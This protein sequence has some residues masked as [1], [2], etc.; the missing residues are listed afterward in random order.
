M[1][2]KERVLKA[3][4]HEITDKVPVDLG[5]NIQATIHAYAYHNLKQGLGLSTDR[6]EIMDTYIMAAKVEDTV[7]DALQIDA[8]PILCPFDSLG[9]RNGPEKK[10]WIMPNGL[11][12]LVSEDFDP[13]KQEDGSYIIEKNGFKFKMP[14]HGYYFDAIHYVL[15]NASTI[16]D[17][18]KGFDFSGY[19]EKEAEYFRREAERLKGSTKAVVGDVFASFSAEDNFGYENAMIYLMAERKL[20]QYFM[21]RLTDMFIRNFDVFH[22]AVGD[23]ADIMMMHKDMGIQQGPMIDPVVA[24]EVFFPLFKKYTSHIKAK[25]NYKVMMHNC[26]SIYEFFPDLIDA[27]IDII[28]PVQISAKNM[29]P[30]K[31]KREF[32]NDICFWGGGVDTQHVLPYGTED[33]VRKQVRENAEI[34][35]HGGGYVFNPVHCV[36]AGVPPKNIIAAFDEINRAGWGKN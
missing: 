16:D 20:I 21:E 32:G 29:E 15:Q 2:S 25:S 26:G 1:T 10:E 35:S 11:K 30:E 17:I 4:N 34:F 22:A 28:N 3:V 19:G 33:E 7:I 12:V 23:V 27:G 18:D 9:M 13:I 5:S 24:R 8:I 14:D 31:L 36:Q 6:I